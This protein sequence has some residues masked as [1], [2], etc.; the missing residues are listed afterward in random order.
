[1]TRGTWIGV[2]GGLIVLAGGVVLAMA[3]PPATEA[4][5]LDRIETLYQGFRASFP[6]V[7]EVQA[8]ELKAKLDAGEPVVL[9]DV[10]PEEEREVSQLPG[11]ITSDEY[12]AKVAGG[13]RG[14]RGQGG[15][16]LL[17]DRRAERVLGPRAA[18]GRSRR[19]QPGRQ[20]AQLEPR[21]W[22]LR[23]PGRGADQAGARLRP[24][25]EPAR[26]RLRGHLVSLRGSA[27]PPRA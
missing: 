12:V 8:P 27:R 2:I 15:R 14:L 26:R 21:R 24:A 7:P 6:G 22:V 1:M 23:G 18:C 9:V 4:G 5:R 16:R 25:L 10:R 17:H 20:R 11:A 13:P 3:S 19:P